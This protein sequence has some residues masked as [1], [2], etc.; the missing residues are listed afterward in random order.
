[1]VRTDSGF[2]TWVAPPLLACSAAVKYWS[3]ALR[4]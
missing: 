4:A 2:S 1:M 3:S